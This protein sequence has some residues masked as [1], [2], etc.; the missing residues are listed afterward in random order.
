MQLENNLENKYQLRTKAFECRAA[1]RQLQPPV[2][3]ALPT[4]SELMKGH[5]CIYLGSDMN[6]VLWPSSRLESHSRNAG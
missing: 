1:I 6:F 2:P 3:P 4:A 5:A